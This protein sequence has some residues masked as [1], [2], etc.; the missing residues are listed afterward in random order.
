VGFLIF[1]ADERRRS[2]E[3]K[4]M[5]RK[6]NAYFDPD[7]VFEAELFKGEPLWAVFS[8]LQDDLVSDALDETHTLALHEPVRQAANEAAGLAWTTEFPLL[9]FPGLFQ[10]KLERTRRQQDRAERIKA[11]TSDFL[12]EAVV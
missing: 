12:L 9:V 11:Q 4:N 7:T 6:L 10:E 2:S 3:E 5:T 8:A 1:G